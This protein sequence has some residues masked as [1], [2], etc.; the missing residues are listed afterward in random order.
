MHTH[1]GAQS[2]HPSSP[3]PPYYT[4][5]LYLYT[6]PFFSLG[7]PCPRPGCVSYLQVL[8]G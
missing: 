7:L 5:N 1:W 6:F 2:A 8:Q 4:I 3:P